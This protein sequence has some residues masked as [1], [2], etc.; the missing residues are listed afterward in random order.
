MS[1]WVAAQFQCTRTL[2]FT[3]PK[4]KINTH[5]MLNSHIIF[6]K[7]TNHFVRC[8]PTKCL[9]AIISFIPTNYQIHGNIP[10]STSH[11]HISTSSRVSFGNFLSVNILRWPL[12][13]YLFPDTNIF[14]YILFSDLRLSRQWLWRMPSFGMLRCVAPVRTDVS[15]ERIFSIIRLTSN[16]EIGTKLAVTVNISTLHGC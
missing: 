6:S 11:S 1:A 2:R 16:G 12:K 9:H 15:E 4:R 8:F 7:W 14:Q 13:I 10:H 5:Q 3:T